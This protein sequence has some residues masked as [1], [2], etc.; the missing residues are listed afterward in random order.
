MN[1]ALL[2]AETFAHGSFDVEYVELFLSVVEDTVASDEVGL[3]KVLEHKATVILDLGP[4]ALYRGHAVLHLGDAAPVGAAPQ[5]ADTLEERLALRRRCQLRFEDRLRV[6]LGHDVRFVSTAWH[7]E[8]HAVGD[9]R[10]VELSMSSL[11]VGLL[12]GHYSTK[13]LDLG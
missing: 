4:R 13:P 9:F 1:A 6:L 5:Q 3:V 2:D 7:V 12:I 8:E 10:L 11:S